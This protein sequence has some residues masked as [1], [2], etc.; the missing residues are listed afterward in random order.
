MFYR[1]LKEF[2]LKKIV[3][4]GLSTNVSDNVN[5]S[6]R[7]VGVFI[8]ET[9][10]NYKTL[11]K[12][13][14]D[15]HNLKFEK[16]DFLIFKDKIKAKEI[17]EEPFFTSKDIRISGV[18]SKQNVVDFTNNTYDLLINFYDEP[19]SILNM[20]ASKSKA[21][22]KVGFTAI[23]KRINN[24]IIHSDTDNAQE[25]VSELVKYLRILNKI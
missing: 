24:L 18:I 2:F 16:V 3:N 22:F 12:N 14:L 20:I 6:I 1:I 7:T 15:K 4:K 5:E 23:D 13:E 19:K 8:D 11:L 17:I 10:G 25:F 9:N 21:R